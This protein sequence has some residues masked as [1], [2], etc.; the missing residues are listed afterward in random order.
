MFISTGTDEVS[1][2]KSEAM[3]CGRV[4]GI[5]QRNWRDYVVSLPDDIEVT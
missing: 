3:P 2:E 4:V 5:L 1:N